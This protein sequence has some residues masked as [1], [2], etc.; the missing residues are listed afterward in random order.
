MPGHL[1]PEFL[2]YQY[3]L[4]P[5]AGLL[6]G[7]MYAACPAAWAFSTFNK[8]LHSSSDPPCSCLFLLRI[9][10]PAYEFVSRDR[11][12]VFPEAGDC[13]CLDQCIDQVNGQIVDKAARNSL[14]HE[15]SLVIV[16]QPNGFSG[17]L[18]VIVAQ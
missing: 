11:R 12:Q 9:L 2:V 4:L 18:A 15:L 3:I 7:A 17:S 10:N 8:L 1:R 13:F 5:L 16:L 14:C 6:V